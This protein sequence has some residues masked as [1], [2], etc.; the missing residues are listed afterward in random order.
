MAFP[1]QERGDESLPLLPSDSVL[2]VVYRSQVVPL[3]LRRSVD[4]THKKK[5]S[6]TSSKNAEVAKQ[7]QRQWQSQPEN[8][9]HNRLRMESIS[10]YWQEQSASNTVFGG[11]SEAPQACHIALSAIYLVTGGS[12]ERH[13]FGRRWQSGMRQL[14]RNRRS[15]DV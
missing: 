1:P 11:V 7:R 4:F 8:Q 10:R 14:A 9:G 15:K 12:F 5:R 6:N 2:D 13:L 3:P